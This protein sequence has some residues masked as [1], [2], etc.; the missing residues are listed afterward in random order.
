MLEENEASLFLEA[1]S[2][3]VLGSYSWWHV[4]GSI[5]IALGNRLPILEGQGPRHEGRRA[6]LREAGFDPRSDTLSEGSRNRREGL[7]VSPKPGHSCSLLLSTSLC[8]STGPPAGP[9]KKRGAE[10]PSPS[11]F[12]LRRR[13]PCQDPLPGLLPNEGLLQSVWAATSFTPRYP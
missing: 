8:P 10:G 9:R 12:S 11:R 5:K 2:K 7:Q 13:C 1:T 3:W 4:E 6:S